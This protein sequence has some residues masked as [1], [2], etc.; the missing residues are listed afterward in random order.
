MI[1]KINVIIKNFEKSKIDELKSI[2]PVKITHGFFRANRTDLAIDRIKNPYLKNHN[3]N[4]VGYV[5][6]SVKDEYI[7][8]ITRKDFVIGEPLIGINPEGKKCTILTN[9]IKTSNG[10]PVNMV[11]PGEIYQVPHVKF[12]TAQTL[13]YK[14]SR[15]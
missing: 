15:S 11:L 2:W 9:D 10:I 1:K 8:L 14:A 5:L 6:E 12:V 3:E 7:A 4:L 13:I